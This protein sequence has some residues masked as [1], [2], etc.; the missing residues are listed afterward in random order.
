MAAAIGINPDKGRIQ[1]NFIL[2][3]KWLI[4]LQR[5]VLIPQITSIFNAINGYTKPA[6]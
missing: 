5:Y 3:G 1:L 6:G 2:T 4:I